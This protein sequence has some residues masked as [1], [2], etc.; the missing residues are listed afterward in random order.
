[1]VRLD[2]LV[3]WDTILWKRFLK[4]FYGRMSEENYTEVFVSMTRLYHLLGT[5]TNTIGEYLR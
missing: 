3:F 5:Y 4:A 2:T 1:M